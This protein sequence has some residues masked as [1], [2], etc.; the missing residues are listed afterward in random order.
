MLEIDLGVT[1]SVLDALAVRS[2]VALHNLANQNT[3]GFKRYGVRFEEF[4]RAAHAS[5][6]DA[7]SVQPVVFRDESG[8]PGVNNVSAIDE[9]GLLNKVSLL[10][11]I[12]TR[13]AA[14]H[15]SKLNQAIRG[16]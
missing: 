9:L 13:R 10:H 11:D 2:K 3:P 7:G 4:L 8:R 5:G 1:Q 16:R 12:F 6:E 14:S 15:I